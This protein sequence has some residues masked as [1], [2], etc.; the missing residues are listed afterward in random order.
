MARRSNPKPKQADP[1]KR[2]VTVL[3]RRLK[4]RREE[5]GL[6]RQD[7][8]ESCDV[9]RSCVRH[10]E[11]GISAP[12]LDRIGLVEKALLLPAGELVCLYVEVKST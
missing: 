8:A 9:D 2:N 1:P 11:L 10:W 12:R 3:H 6:S 7:V 4:E 5:L